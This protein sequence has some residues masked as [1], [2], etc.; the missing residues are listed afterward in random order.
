MY[1]CFMS[2]EE[3]KQKLIDGLKQQKKLMR[4]NAELVEA[5]CPEL[6]Y[7]LELQSAADITHSWL[8]EISKK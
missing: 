4:D 1:R 3:K 2:K 8:N 5:V 6:G 7:Q